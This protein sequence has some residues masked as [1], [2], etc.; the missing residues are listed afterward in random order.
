MFGSV[1]HTKI[2]RY[3][4]KTCPHCNE[5]LTL[6]RYKEHERLYYDSDTKVWIKRSTV[7]TASHQGCLSSESDSD[8]STFDDIVE[9]A[10][11]PVSV[12]NA[13]DNYMD[14]SQADNRSVEIQLMRRFCK[15]NTTLGLI[16]AARS[17][18]LSEVFAQLLPDTLSTDEPQRPMNVSQTGDFKLGAKY[19]IA[20]LSPDL[21]PL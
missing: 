5:E 2:A 1:P 8:L 18:P 11:S 17:W 3:S 13:I 16:G 19:I 14:L 9:T 12:V 15:D 20:S 10:N 21:V 7:Y 4:Y 6:K